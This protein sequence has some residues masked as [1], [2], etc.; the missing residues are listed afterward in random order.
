MRQF[1]IASAMTATALACAVS[2][3]AATYNIEPTHTFVTFEATHF[4]T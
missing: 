2:A 4:G 3:Q 1:F